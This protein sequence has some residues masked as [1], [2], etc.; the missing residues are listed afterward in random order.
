[1]AKRSVGRRL[2][3]LS[4]TGAAVHHRRSVKAARDGRIRTF[5]LSKGIKLEKVVKGKR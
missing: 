4:K 3:S 1:M 2:D 5:K